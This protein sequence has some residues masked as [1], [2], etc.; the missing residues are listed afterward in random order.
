D[1]Y[2][3]GEQYTKKLADIFALQDE[4]AGEV[5]EALKLKLTGEPKKRAARPTE[6]TEAYH[7]YLKGRFYW[8]KRTP[9]DIKKAIE[10]YQKALN[11]DPNYALVYVGLAD[12]YASLAM[13]P[14]GATRPVEAFPRA[15]AAAQRALALDGSLGEAYASLGLCALYFDWDWAAS[16]SAFRR[17]REIRPEYINAH[18]WYAVLLAVMGRFEEAIQVARRATEIDP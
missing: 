12:C 4:I 18:S 6:N 9:E 1:A 3:W 2:V 16:E 5:L 10:L 14:F 7:L 11:Q 8:A 17:C 15:K 13:A